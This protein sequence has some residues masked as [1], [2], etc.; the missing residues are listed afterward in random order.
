MPQFLIFL[1][2]GYTMSKLML[3]ALKTSY[4]CLEGY[5]N[6]IKNNLFIKVVF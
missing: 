6:F 4:F 1:C 3:K 5:F 2:L